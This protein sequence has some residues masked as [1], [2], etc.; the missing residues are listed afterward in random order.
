MESK[1]IEIISEY[2]KKNQPIAMVTIVGREG[3]NP[4]KVGT[5][6]VVDEKGHVLSGSIGGGIIEKMARDDVVEAM[7]DCVSVE[8]SYDL[9]HDDDMLGMKCTGHVRVFI[10]IY[11][12]KDKLIIIGAGHLGKHIAYYAKPLNY[13]VHIMDH[14][15]GLT[16]GKYEDAYTY[17]GDI[18]DILEEM[19]I[20]EKTSIVVVTHAHIYDYE[21]LV[22]TI[23]KPYRYL[24]M[25]GSKKKIK[26]CYDRLISDGHSVDNWDKVATPI[27]LDIGGRTPQ[28]IALAVVAEIQLNKYKRTGKLY[29][30]VAVD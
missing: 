8:K 1:M 30:E 10:K 18:E 23:D 9:S 14:R 21:A 16:H 5:A 2:Q 7:I 22:K 25:V 24:G 6:M 12:S 15:Q 28:E 11:K 4:R 3:C 27:G 13:E 26:G 19:V 20:D 17:E 29:K